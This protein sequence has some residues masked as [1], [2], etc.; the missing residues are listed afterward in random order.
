M[1][2]EF[3]KFIVLAIPIT[4]PRMRPSQTAPE[5]LRDDLLSESD[6]C[7]VAAACAAN[8][9]CRCCAAFIVLKCAG[10]GFV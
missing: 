10:F 2:R 7:L 5:I 8:T 6:V 4:V 3:W 9:C 1:I